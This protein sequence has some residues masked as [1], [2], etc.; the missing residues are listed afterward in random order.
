MAHIGRV[1]RLCPSVMN[2]VRD[3]RRVADDNHGLNLLNAQRQR[4]GGPLRI[5]KDWSTLILLLSDP[6]VS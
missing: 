5:G 1:P 4:E 3:E 6:D 2:R